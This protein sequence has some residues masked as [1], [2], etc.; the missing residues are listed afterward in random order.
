MAEVITSVG[1]V[2]TAVIGWGG[3]LLSFIVAQPLLMIPTTL[4]LI[5]GTIGVIKRV[6]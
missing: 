1:S 4:G 3:S 6:K 5:G 2:V